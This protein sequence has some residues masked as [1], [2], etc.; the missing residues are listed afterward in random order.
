MI[1][2]SNKHSFLFHIIL[3]QTSSNSFFGLFIL[4]VGNDAEILQIA[5]G[6]GSCCFSVYVL[7]LAKHGAN[8]GASA[9]NNFPSVMEGCFLM[10]SQ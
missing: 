2:W 10:G 8:A 7:V 6:E 1:E 5:A 3:S 9:V 4:R